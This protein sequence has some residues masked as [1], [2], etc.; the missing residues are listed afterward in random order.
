MVLSVAV[1]FIIQDWRCMRMLAQH[2][3]IAFLVIMGNNGVSHNHQPAEKDKGS[4][5]FNPFSQILIFL[6]ISWILIITQNNM[7]FFIPKFKKY[8]LQKTVE[9]H[10]KA[11]LSEVPCII[12]Y[13]IFINKSYCTLSL[14]YLNSQ[15]KRIGQITQC[16]SCKGF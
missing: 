15:H 11:I 3:K 12:F 2:V 13:D 7:L 5:D 1:I 8:Y 14:K 16:Y 6:P 4:F 10:S 9:K